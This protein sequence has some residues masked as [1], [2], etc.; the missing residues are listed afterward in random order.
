MPRYKFSEIAYNINQKKKPEPGDEEMYIGLEHL[1][2]GSLKVRKWGS[3]VPITGEKLVMKKGDILFG[4]RNTYLR[5]AAIAPHNGIFSAHGMIFR[6]NT[7]VMDADYFPFFISSDYFMNA[8]IRISVGSLSPTV[9][10][11]TL[12]DLEFDVPDIE[13][14]RKSAELLTAANELR[15]AY[16][17]LLSETDELVKSQFI[18][19]FGDPLLNPKGLPEKK[20]EELTD[21]IGSGATPKGGN[22]SYKDEGISLIRSMHVYNGYFDYDDLA[23]IDEEQA[24]KLDNVTVNEGDVLL[25]ITGAS[26]ARSC[27]VPADILPARVNQHVCIIRCKQDQVLPHYINRLLIGDTY[28]SFLWNMASAAGAT[29]Q[30][31]TKEQIQNL[32]I[33]VPPLEEQRAYMS[34]VE[35]SDKSKFEIKRSID[36]VKEL[37]KSLMQQDFTN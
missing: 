15:E 9:N 26:V 28:Q 36:S 1:E 33:I 29:R 4:R 5:R 31:L 32:K 16:E 18:E 27:V 6:P 20:L 7:E 12:K 14:Q 21:K 24:R 37:I 19:M 8:A 3:D 13:S 30:A 35:Q 23:H 11:K 25:N 10:W 17:V 22:A 2:S 34:F